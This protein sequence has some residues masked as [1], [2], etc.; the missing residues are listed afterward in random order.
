M[1]NQ[2]VFK[3]IFAGLCET[4][5]REATESLGRIYWAILSR[6][7]DAEVEAAVM[8]GLRKWR[9]F[10]R[11][12]EIVE[13]IEGS[14]ETRAWLAWETF[15]AAKARIGAVRSVLFEDP[16]IPAVVDLLG[17]W[18]EEG[19]FS[20]LASEYAFRRQEFIRAYVA[21]SAD[22]PAR[23]R[24]L[25]GWADADNAARGHMS[26]VKP[27]RLIGMRAGV[28]HLDGKPLEARVPSVAA[29][30]SPGAPDPSDSGTVPVAEVMAEVRRM[31]EGGMFGDASCGG[32]RP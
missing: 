26:H 27:P 31:L 2:A 30:P 21:L 6:Y 7:E 11:P 22:P 1:K 29:L 10:P 5:G 8:R 13:E 17:G 3:A 15:E 24:P 23:S 14:P 20:W 12:A 19:V 18:R 25:I 4:F 32:V 9:F 28:L 16:V